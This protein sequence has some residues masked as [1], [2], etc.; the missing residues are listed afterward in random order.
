MV[1]ALEAFSANV[2]SV[3]P[4]DHD[5]ARK[6]ANMSGDALV[7]TANCPKGFEHLGNEGWFDYL[8]GLN[9]R[10]KVLVIGGLPDSVSGRSFRQLEMVSGTEGVEGVL[11]RLRSQGILQPEVIRKLRSRVPELNVDELGSMLRK[12]SVVS[13]VCINAT[14]LRKLATSLG[15]DVFEQV[16]G[17]L[18]QSLL[19]MWGEPGSFRSEDILCHRR[20]DSLVFYIILHGARGR[21]LVPA[22][23]VL[24]RLGERITSRLLG[25]L[26]RQIDHSRPDKEGGSLPACVRMIPEIAAGHATV[27]HNPC[28]NNREQIVQM[29]ESAMDTAR[30]QLLRVTDRQ[31]ELLLTIIKSDE[32]LEPAFQAVFDLKALDLSNASRFKDGSALRTS[33]SA[34]YGFE[35]LIRIKSVD[36]DR[37]FFPDPVSF[38]EGR[39]L[40][41][42]VLFALAHHARLALELDQACLRHALKASG[43]LPGTLMVNILPRNLYHVDAIKEWI[44]DR[45][46]VVLEVS[47]SEEIGNFDKLGEVCSLL[48]KQNL[49]VAADDFGKGFAGLDRILKMRPDLIKIDRALVSK[50]DLDP[51]RQTFLK[52]LLVAANV[53]GSMVL[54]EGI[55]R[56]EEARFC[57][58]NG[59]DLVQGFLFHKP[60]F[61]ADLNV[62]LGLDKAKVTPA[63]GGRGGRGKLSGA[64]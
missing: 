30:G 42:D 32:L 61:R 7:T 12:D 15:N 33:A 51:A 60:Q 44:G 43:G 36:F 59:V 1:Q 52:S 39:I 57:Q 25:R 19:E 34:I 18:R 17:E 35:S 41:P 28:V 14:K 31:R 45:A 2:T 27:V 24:E 54:A 64:A 13:L 10:F 55:E 26:W 9:Q 5:A 22:P 63:K 37:R 56:I 38:F 53:A 16:V 46:N 50:I 40:Q 20:E 8:N 3:S 49:K 11:I 4:D 6:L 47:E 23:G 62:A 29:M 48:R 58:E 21:D